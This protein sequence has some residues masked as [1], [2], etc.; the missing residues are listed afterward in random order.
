MRQKETTW[1]N[2]AWR[3]GE[4]RGMA[5]SWD[6]TPQLEGSQGLSCA[7]LGAKAS[8]CGRKDHLSCDFILTVPHDRGPRSP[9]LTLRQ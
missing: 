2:Q 6:P 3:K 8:L 4:G 7:L 9:S 5:I 1:Q